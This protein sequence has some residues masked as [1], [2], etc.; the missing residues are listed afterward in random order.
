MKDDEPINDPELVKRAIL[1]GILIL[2]MIV[3][4]ALSEGRP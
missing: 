1:C 3:G 2:I 4:R